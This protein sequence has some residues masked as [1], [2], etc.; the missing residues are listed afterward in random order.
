MSDSFII[1]FALTIAAM[2]AFRIFNARKRKRQET[3]IANGVRVPGQ[4]VAIRRQSHNNDLHFVWT[5]VR[6]IDPDTGREAIIEYSFDQH[7]GMPSSI[8]AVGHG[9][10]KFILE[11]RRNKK[12]KKYGD[13]LVEQGLPLD[14]VNA[15]VAQRAHEYDSWIPVMNGPVDGDGYLILPTPVEVGVFLDKTSEKPGPPAVAFD[16]GQDF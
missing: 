11:G 4:M 10:S 5:K 6:Y 9:D 8:Y 2:V 7:G 16:V 15:M 3:T 13:G 1:I 14:Q 12:L